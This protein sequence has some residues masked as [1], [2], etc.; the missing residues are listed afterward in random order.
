MPNNALFPIEDV[1]AIYSHLSLEVK[2]TAFQYG[3]T[4]GYPPLIE[5]VKTYL[6]SKGLNLEGHEL[7]ITAGSLQA[8]N[9]V[10]K[11]FID[12]GDGVLTEDP[13]FI[14]AISALNPT[15]QDCNLSLWE[16][17]GYKFQNLKKR[18]RIDLLSPNSS[19]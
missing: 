8:I 6:R 11:V 19:T 12:P 10:A 1:D 13:C 4:P 5:S 9:L 7:L 17:R 18:L 15:R 3:P 14:G 16:K 2:Q